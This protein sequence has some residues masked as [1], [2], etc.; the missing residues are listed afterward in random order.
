M[1]GHNIDNICI[2]ALSVTLDRRLLDSSMR[3]VGR[4]QQKVADLKASDRWSV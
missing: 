1:A 3:S 4:L 2:E